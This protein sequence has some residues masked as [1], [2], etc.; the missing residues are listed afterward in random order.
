MNFLPRAGLLIK[1]KENP[2]IDFSNQFIKTDDQATAVAE[3]VK[4]YNFPILAVKF[5]NNG[6]QARQSIIIMK[7]FQHH[8]GI[9]QTL[10]MSSN[11]LGYGGA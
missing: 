11:N 10:N 4:R 3:A 7:S 6:L 2:V 5:V 1:D 8:N 9:L